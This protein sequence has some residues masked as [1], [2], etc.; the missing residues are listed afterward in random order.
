MW[1]RVQCKKDFDFP[2]STQT[3]LHAQLQATA[4]HPQSVCVRAFR[5]SRP[6]V[7]LAEICSTHAETCNRVCFEKINCLLSVICHSAGNGPSSNARSHEMC[8]LGFE[9]TEWVLCTPF[10][11]ILTPASAAREAGAILQSIHPSHDPLLFS[12]TYRAFAL[13]H[14]LLAQNMNRS[15]KPSHTWFVNVSCSSL[16]VQNS[17]PREHMLCVWNKVIA[18]SRA[19]LLL[20]SLRIL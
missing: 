16:N 14:H 19:P 11:S 5:P 2:Y 3:V 6:S 20:F 12:R 17:P 18:R 9:K 10:L 13:P 15:S 7:S 1:L 8:Y 4:T